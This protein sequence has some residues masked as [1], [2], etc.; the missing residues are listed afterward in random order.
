MW[1]SATSLHGLVVGLVCMLSNTQA[2]LA[3]LPATSAAH[4]CSLATLPELCVSACSFALA[5]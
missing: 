4:P 3:H 5:G 1:E 2:Q